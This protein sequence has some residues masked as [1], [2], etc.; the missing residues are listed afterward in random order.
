M[1]IIMMVKLYCQILVNQPR[2]SAED[3]GEF[4]DMV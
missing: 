2:I 4:F 3:K 1:Y